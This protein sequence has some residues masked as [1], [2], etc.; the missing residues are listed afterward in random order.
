MISFKKWL[1]PENLQG[2]GGGPE[3]QPENQ[4]ELA[5]KYSQL[6]AGAFPHFEI[7]TKKSTSPTSRYADRRFNKK[8]M[9]SDGY[10]KSKKK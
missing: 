8:F 5:G 10:C 6:G 1:F 4:E 9:K 2:P 3:P 7:N